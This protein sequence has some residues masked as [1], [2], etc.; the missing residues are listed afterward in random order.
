MVIAMNDGTP[1]N[2]LPPA[3]PCPL[4]ELGEAD[5]DRIVANARA[6]AK[7]RFG[8]TDTDIDHI[9]VSTIGDAT[10]PGA[11]TTRAFGDLRYCKDVRRNQVASGV[12]AG[13]MSVH[14]V[15]TLTMLYGMV[16]GRALSPYLGTF[17]WSAI[18]AATAV[19]AYQLRNQL[20][21]LGKL[22]WYGTGPS[23]R[24]TL[25]L[26]AVSL[27]TMILRTFVK[28]RV[29]VIALVAVVGMLSSVR[30]YLATQS[31]LEPESLYIAAGA[32]ALN[33]MLT[34]RKISE[35]RAYYNDAQIKAAQAR[36][37]TKSTKSTAN[38]KTSNSPPASNENNLQQ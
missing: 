38:A 29:G 23:T 5:V 26:T 20:Q 8:L 19:T 14:L 35:A 32:A 24:A 6:A 10:H 28:N 3:T 18:I 15:I 30:L 33:R 11:A 36:A 16:F 17:S 1:G 25:V 21:L 34:V 37:A 12:Y 27:T 7:L 31:T 4:D 2:A 9:V 22:V 13:V